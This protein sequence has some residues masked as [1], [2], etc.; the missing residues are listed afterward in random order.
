MAINVHI[1]T[2]HT[3]DSKSK[4]AIAVLF[5][6]SGMVVWTLFFLETFLLLFHLKFL[7][8]CCLLVASWFIAVAQSAARYCYVLLHPSWPLEDLMPSKMSEVFA[9]LTLATLTCAHANTSTVSHV[10]TL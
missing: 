5:M 9:P 10:F 8:T 1:H 3:S 6:S 7:D 4:L 2:S